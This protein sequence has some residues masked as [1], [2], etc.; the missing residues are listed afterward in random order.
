MKRHPLSG[1][2]LPP[3]AQEDLLIFPLLAAVALTPMTSSDL[4]RLMHLGTATTCKRLKRLESLGYVV[5]RSDNRWVAVVRLRV[6]GAIKP[7]GVPGLDEG[8]HLAVE[9][10]TGPSGALEDGLAGISMP[11]APPRAVAVP[12]EVQLTPSQKLAR[13]FKVPEIIDGLGAVGIGAVVGCL[14]CRK[15]TPLKYG[16]SALCPSCSREIEAKKKV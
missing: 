13:K 1:A 14:H 2:R 4:A 15:P 10:P 6:E 11:H 7:V 8:A 12:Q 9:P 5:K 3:G 16:V